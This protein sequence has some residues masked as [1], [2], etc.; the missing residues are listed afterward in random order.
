LGEEI[1]RVS[2]PFLPET[3]ER[4]LDIFSIIS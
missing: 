2:V 4:S 3:K 1:G